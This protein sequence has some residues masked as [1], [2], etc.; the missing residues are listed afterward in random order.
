MAEQ[1]AKL[2]KK[3]SSLKAKLT[4]F[5]NY[6]S[7]LYSCT[8]L[9]PLQCREL[10]GRLN[11][12]DALYD[13]F[14]DLQTEIEMLS[15][16]PDAEMFAER[17]EFEDQYH[18]QV[19]LARSL[20]ADNHVQD[21]SG[22]AVGSPSGG[23]NKNNF[24][25]L[26]KID[27][28]HFDG[29]FQYWL[30]FRD[31]FIS[32]I[33]SNDCIDHI[34]KF[35]YLRSSLKGS[36]AIVIKGIHFSSENYQVAW[37]L[38]CERYN[39]NRLLI[40][41]HV[42][43]LF[44]VEPISKEC[45]RSLRNLID[46]TNKNIRALE[47]LNEPTK[48][49]DTLII[50]MM[51]TK[52]DL[53]TSRYWLEY[54]NTLK[55][56]PTLNQFCTFISNRVDLLESLE[57][58]SYHQNHYQV[59]N[60][61]KNEIRKPKSFIVESN[62]NNYNQ[63]KQNPLKCPLCSKNHYLYTCETFKNLTIE[64]RIEKAKN[65]KVCLNCLRPGHD[66][67][68][69]RLSHCKYC[70]YKHNTLLHLDSHQN[71][72]SNSIIMPSSE[73]VVLSSNTVQ[74]TASAVLLSTALVKVVDNKGKQHPTRILLDNG[75]TTNFITQGLCNKLGL[76]RHKA[77][78]TVTGINNQT[79]Y[80]TQSCNLSIES[81]YGGYRVNVD[82][83]ILPEIT[84]LLPSRLINRNTIPIPKGLP[85]ADPSFNIP[86][87]IDVLLGADLFWQLIDNNIIDL[88]RNQPKL[89]HSKLGWL[90]SGH[91]GFSPSQFGSHNCNYIQDSKPDL[92][93]F[94]ELDTVSSSHS[95]SSEEKACEES[96]KVNTVRNSNGR[97]VVTMPFKQDPSLLGDS[98]EMAKRRFLSLERRFQRDPSF[99]DSY[100]A[101]MQEY[102]Q[103]GHMVEDSLPTYS[104][105]D[106]ISYFLPHHG[107]VR[108]SST[109]TKLRTVFDASA[110]TTTGISLNDLQMVGPVVQD[111]L[112]SILLRFR[113]HKIVIT[114]DVEKMYRSIELNS[115][116]RSLQRIIFRDDPSKPLKTYT[117]N[118][119]TY[120]TASAPYLAT[121]CLVS[122]ASHAPNYD[123]KRCIQHD[124]YVDDLLTGSS[125]I[126]AT[127]D[128]C[129]H[130][131]SILSSAQ[132]NLRKW[133]SNCPEI[134][135]KI[136]QSFS[137]TSNILDLNKNSNITSSKTL[138]LHWFCDS[139]TLSFFINIDLSKKVT[140]RHILS[141]ISQIFDPLGLVGP[142]VVEAKII[143][144]KLWIEKYDWDDEVSQ[145]IKKLW[146]SFIKTLNYLNNLK[147]PRWVL[148][149]NSILHEIHVFTDSS[150][151]AY[152]AC[153]YVRSITD[154]GIVN[155]QLLTSKN[156]VAPI[157]P[158]TI[159]RL[160]LCG[161][162]LGTRLC[163]KVL[164]SLTLPI[165]KCYFWCDSTI[166]LSWLATPSNQ[167][168]NFVRN[169]VNEIQESTNGHTWGYVSSKDN[170]ADLVSRGVSADNISNSILWWKGPTFLSQ[171]K[172]EWPQKPFNYEKQDLPDVSAD[173]CSNFC[174][175]SINVPNQLNN[176]QKSIIQNL[177]QKYSNYNYLQRIVAYIQ[178]F[179]HNCSIKN[180]NTKLTGPLRTQEL[181]NSSILILKHAQL[182][183]F[184]EEFAI[185][186]SGKLLSR[187]NRLI[188]LTPFL[189]VNKIIR[190]GGRL[191]NSPY[192][193]DTKHPILLCSKH[194]LTKLI[195]QTQHVKLLHAGPQLLLANIRQNYW[196][197]KGK[198]LA[199]S[200]VNNCLKCFRFKAKSSQ[201]LMGQLPTN[202]THLEFPFL[203]SS[204]D[205][206]GPV[207]IADRKGRGC[208]LLKSYICIFVC[209]AVKAVHIE[210]VTD[211]TKEA[212]MA[213]L[214]RFIA[215]R[216]KPRSISSDNGTNFVGAS[217]EI[218]K[219]LQTSKIASEMAQEGIDFVFA[220]AYSPHF[221]GIAEAA[222]KSTKYHL[223]R[224]MQLTHFTF[225]EMCTCLTQIE[226]IL[227]SRPLTPLSSDPL[228]F[229]A[230]T[231]A[232]FL[233]GRSLTSVPHPPIVGVDISRLQ[234]YQRIE[235][236]RRH[237]WNR[238]NL[239]YVSQLQH[240]TKWLESSGDLAMGSLVLV[241]EK[242]LP[243]LMWC[244]GRVVAV[245]PGGDGITRV[246]EIKTKRGTIRR[247]FNNV[248]PLPLH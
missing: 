79:S 224:L 131:K 26:P 82:C 247:G 198:N 146:Y 126:A 184:P 241:K 167:L 163:T 243:P 33:H 113:Q 112:F 187:K 171:N 87:A 235:S 183:M 101:F 220:P 157:K 201:P 35:H 230:L 145:N 56:A 99:R 14:D 41:N 74:V 49:W 28:P 148:C 119:V 135:A 104:V 213:A 15:D 105:N 212:Y 110:A 219:F 3:R 190:V 136:D 88:G 151:K 142:C 22:S 174:N 34:N 54:H 170:P 21:C 17:V 197:I 46:I 177:I 5:K 63:N 160:E 191:N 188:S 72:T 114:A 178:R 95:L 48:Y 240:K 182:E 156:R 180:K 121:K 23:T 140:K 93:Q 57:N 229:S 6:L 155:V 128:M 61:N 137:K 53:T 196:P 222:V 122:L 141:V 132:F 158:I 8:S 123:V 179:I 208:K 161:A 204:V 19:A 233:I 51:S 193:Y 245:Y 130:V 129:N 217:N 221:N 181:N 215:R 203:H 75:S 12:F 10:D 195:F 194:Q 7:G 69:C 192:D 225:E 144:Q 209:Q 66:H 52:L 226:A 37:D 84:K 90:V 91:V 166:V 149:D 85:L 73:N 172:D 42:Q 147:I 234:R 227:N 210:L 168:K 118:T 154:A 246:V 228:D 25:R 124:F 43:A 106:H 20:L 86:S 50:Y 27:L 186:A 211:L 62:I 18:A 80:S 97:F 115:K 133:Q 81:Y 76:S 216:G 150:E 206:A 58:Q 232:H 100:I 83:L 92:S 64:N 218:V 120:G 32:L 199:K 107:V 59:H 165:D 40:N 117:L 36:A 237:F 152:G 176:N 24:V 205:Y 78:S 71:P 68:K 189:D 67:Q 116:Q 2:I 103:L 207:L 236:I 102:E 98:F 89:C 111:D 139:D 248:C 38:L 30:E 239:E 238:F 60:T 173:Y 44:S 13:E 45:S 29:S 77:S 109:T 214:N 242:T 31:T 108:T 70:K 185:L 159:P 1:Y 4:I 65:F 138:G 169:R 11:K 244:L 223:R 55:D 164:E 231:P 202:R 162:L 134:L 127:L 39:N 143:M 94:W 125:T 96:F 9:S 16:K 200:T 153:I 47:T 175:K